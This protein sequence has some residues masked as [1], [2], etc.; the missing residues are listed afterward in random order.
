MQALTSTMKLTPIVFFAFNRPDTT[1]H[2]LEALSRQSKAIPRL[3]AFCDGA[4]HQEEHTLVQQVRDLVRAVTWT[5]VEIIERERNY[6]LV[7]NIV[8]GL[9]DVFSR[10]ERAIIVED[11]I[12]TAP[13]F[14]E[15]LCLL[16]DHYQSAHNVFSVG[17]YPSIIPA[18]LQMYP[19]DIIMS[20]RFSMWGWGTWAERW[21][22]VTPHIRHFKNP[23][24]TPEA[25]GQVMNPDMAHLMRELDKNPQ[26]TWDVQVMV[27]THSQDYLHALSR[28]YLSNNLGLDSGIHFSKP[29]NKHFLRF[30]THNNPL[31]SVPPQRFAPPKRD[32]QVIEAV[33]RYIIAAI[34]AAK[35]QRFAKLRYY[36]RRLRHHLQ[37]LW[38]GTE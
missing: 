18:D 26:F 22:A 24:G 30:I 1:R 13:H 10:Y 20:M 33:N 27:W 21:Q 2:I 9:D 12:L 38:A 36:L 11:D 35:Y 25:V 34:R 7:E 8:G 37:R 4:R 28:R 3:I 6:G 5:E 32:E 15:S 31:E 17:A 16:L 14:Y 29:K 19:Y 23:Y